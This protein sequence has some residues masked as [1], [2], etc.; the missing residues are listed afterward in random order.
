MVVLIHVI[1]GISG[2][3]EKDGL[4]QITGIKQQVRDNQETHIVYLIGKTLKL[5]LV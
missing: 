2:W 3:R 1:R 5:K 4:Y